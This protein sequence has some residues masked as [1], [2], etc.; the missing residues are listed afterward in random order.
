MNE[1][2]D[3]PSEPKAVSINLSVENISQGTLSTGED[4][5][6]A[7]CECYNGHSLDCPTLGVV[8]DK[9]IEGNLS[10]GVSVPCDE[11]TLHCDI[12]TMHSMDERFDLVF[13][14]RKL[15]TAS[16]WDGDQETLTFYNVEGF[17]AFGMS[18]IL[19][20]VLMIDIRLGI[21]QVWRGDDMLWAADLISCIL[22]LEIVEEAKKV[23][24][25][26]VSS[27]VQG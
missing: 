19:G 17:A 8:K 26:G 20:D 2:P 23:V 11:P 25:T 10:T 3:T 14:G 9:L 13:M 24:A 21:G 12:A 22:H 18:T 1:N 27:N 6:C 16:G 15:G 7:V 4:A 5:Y